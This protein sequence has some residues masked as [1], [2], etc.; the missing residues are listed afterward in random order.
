MLRTLFWALET[1]IEFLHVVVY[2][3][4]FIVGHEPETVLVSCLRPK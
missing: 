4:D 2:E 3:G 1:N